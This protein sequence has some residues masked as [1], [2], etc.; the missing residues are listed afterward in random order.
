MSVVDVDI[1]S[2]YSESTVYDSEIVERNIQDY[3]RNQRLLQYGL[4]SNILENESG[5][6]D[7]NLPEQPN[8][9][10]RGRLKEIA[11]KKCFPFIRRN[12]ILILFILV[13]IL[14]TV[15]SIDTLW[16]SK[17]KNE[18]SEYQST[19]LDGTTTTKFIPHFTIK[20]PTKGDN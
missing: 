12:K 2:V 18:I 10:S 13:I 17:Y 5:N 8:S 1:T 7:E 20:P 9:P 3:E 19:T 11:F 15:I 6:L 4:F 14:T 16:L